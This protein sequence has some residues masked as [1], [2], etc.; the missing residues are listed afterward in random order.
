[1]N[2]GLASLI[3]ILVTVLILG[4]FVALF[5][6]SG[7]LNILDSD[8]TNLPRELTKSIPS[9]LPLP[10]L[11]NDEILSADQI[12]CD[13]FIETKTGFSK[14]IA[15]LQTTQ[16]SQKKCSQN[17]KIDISYSGKYLAFEDI[18][19]GIDSVLKLYSIDLDQTTILE[20]L[21]T[22][23]IFDFVFTVNDKLALVSGYRDKFDEQ[24]LNVYDINSLYSNYSQ[25]LLSSEGL[26]EDYF[27]TTN[28]KEKLELENIG[29]NY[30]GLDIEG[31]TLVVYSEN[32]TT[33]SATF[34]IK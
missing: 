28:F 12:G 32:S 24:W 3:G 11:G 33:P 29:K 9:S 7:V 30:I 8:I 34:E 27:D 22:S 26:Y 5:L 17:I 25:N 6:N 13:I 1:M 31:N 16:D 20:V 2:K 21:G 18:L 23:D 19:G 4:V 14:K 15:T 10:K